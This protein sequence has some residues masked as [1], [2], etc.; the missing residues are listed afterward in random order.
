[1]GQDEHSAPGTP[2]VCSPRAD[3]W[4]VDK[5]EDKAQSQGLSDFGQV[6]RAFGKDHSPPQRRSDP[7]PRVLPLRPSVSYQPELAGV[8]PGWVFTGRVTFQGTPS[9]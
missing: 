2:A 7:G 6:S 4:L 1:M 5:G 9:H 8:V 3:N